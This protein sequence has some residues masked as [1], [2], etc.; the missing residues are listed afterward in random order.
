MLY[1]FIENTHVGRICFGIFGIVVLIVT[2]RIVHRT[3]FLTWIGASIAIPAIVLLVLQMTSDRPGYATWSAGLESLS[4]FYA[5][6]ALIAYMLADRRA[7]T[8]ELF[9]AAATFTLLAWAFAYLFLMVQACSQGPSPAC[10]SRTR[11]ATGPS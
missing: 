4:Y 2:L 9:A 8:D 5:A 7:T 1:P 10:A 11:R 3:P 6:G